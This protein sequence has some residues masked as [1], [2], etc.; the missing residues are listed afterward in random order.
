MVERHNQRECGL[1]S[2]DSVDVS[3]VL[4]TRKLWAKLFEVLAALDNGLVQWDD[5]VAL[6]VPLILEL[7]LPGIKER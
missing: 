3:V 5:F 7:G 6:E 1:S 2:L 4:Q